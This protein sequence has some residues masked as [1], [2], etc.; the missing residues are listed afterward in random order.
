MPPHMNH[1]LD[2][3]PIPLSY[4]EDFELINN[5]I[6]QADAQSDELVDDLAGMSFTSTPL[7]IQDEVPEKIR[8]WREEKER[9]LEE[10]DRMEQDAKESLRIAAQKEMSDWSSKYNESMDRTKEMNRQNEKE[11]G[12]FEAQDNDAKNM[13]ESIAGLCDFSAKGPKNAKDASRM[14][15]IFLQMKSTPKV[16]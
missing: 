15:S 9:K 12:S 5:E 1:H 6:Q 4:Q 7:K 8:A 11:Y 10:K 13:W 16:N 3:S 2:F 14:R